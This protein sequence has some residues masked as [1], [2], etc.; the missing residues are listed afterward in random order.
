MSQDIGTKKQSLPIYQII[1]NLLD[2]IFRERIEVTRL[3][4]ADFTTVK[5][6]KITELKEKFEHTKSK[7]FY[8]KSANRYIIHLI[9]GDNTYCRMK[10]KEVYKGKSGEPIVEGT[11]FGYIIHSGD[12]TS[13]TCMYTKDSTDYE[14]LYI[15]DI[16]G[17]E[18]KGENN[19]S[20]IHRNEN[21]SRQSDGRYEINIR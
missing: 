20:D 9:L 12:N 3:N 17:V 14:R 6:P 13:S 21:I 10:T 2:G 4:L 15:P 5:R 19:L 8:T 1:T 11:T 18:D 7:R 16:L